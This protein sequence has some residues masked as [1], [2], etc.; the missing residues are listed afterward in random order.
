M[1]DGLETRNARAVHVVL[2]YAGGGK[3]RFCCHPERSE[4]S[5]FCISQG[6]S[7]FFGQNPPSE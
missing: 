6:K 7:G 4:G 1:A 5:A 3:G 2:A